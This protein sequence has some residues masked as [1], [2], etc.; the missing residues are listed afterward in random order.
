MNIVVLESGKELWSYVRDY[1]LSD[2]ASDGHQILPEDDPSA[3]L[4]HLKN[5]VEP[6]I[7]LLGHK[8]YGSTSLEWCRQARKIEAFAR[9]FIIFAL[10]DDRVRS[11]I[12]A[13]NSGA[14]DVLPQPWQADILKAKIFA[15]L[16]TQTHQ[17][18]L[19]ECLQRRDNLLTNVFSQL[20]PDKTNNLYAINLS[21]QNESTVENKNTEPTAQ[22]NVSIKD[23]FRILSDIVS[24]EQL[25]LAVAETLHSMKFSESKPVISGELRANQ[26]Y[27][28]VH[29]LIL[30]EK[31]LWLD[32]LLE[33]DI[34]SVKQLYESFSG[35]SSSNASESDFLD[36]LSETLN[37]IQAAIK[38]RIKAAKCEAFAPLVPQ[39]VP[40]NYVTN[41]V[42]A[43]CYSRKTYITKNIR[44]QFSLLA[45][46]RQVV[47]KPLKYIRQGDVL[48]EP[49]KVDIDSE[50][51]II[52][53]G[54]IL[55][56]RYFEKASSMAKVAPSTFK[57]P[58]IE[59]SP[60]VSIIKKS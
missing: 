16:R 4:E 43:D 12:D 54:T 46:N 33:T 53:K 40:S 23:S 50:I 48:V 31:M 39:A 17:K 29:F 42:L 55:I 24:P 34:E 2:V 6:V 32:L 49:L 45:H 36:A 28:L 25:E 22:S 14:D 18:R 13:L 56:G 7:I 10:A 1:V 37:M 19:I 51:V 3:L 27:S 30:P 20:K 35:T 26:T 60:F 52:Q 58:I 11:M 8:I 59:P 15:A 38:A 47:L 44:L 41:E 5:E 21:K 57:Q 9:P